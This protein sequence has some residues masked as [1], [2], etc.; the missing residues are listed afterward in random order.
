MVNPL[1]DIQA[2]IYTSILKA[3]FIGKEAVSESVAPTLNPVSGVK[4]GDP[5]F[6]TSMYYTK[7]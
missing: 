2:Y 1:A 7:T 3:S 6:E 5:H 4:R